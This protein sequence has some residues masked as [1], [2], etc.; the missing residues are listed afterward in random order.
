MN[1][2]DIYN[3]EKDKDLTRCWGRYSAKPITGTHTE[4]STEAVTISQTNR[5]LLSRFDNLMTELNGAEW[6]ELAESISVD[7][8]TAEMVMSDTADPRPV[9]Q[10]QTLYQT[11][12][13]LFGSW[14]YTW[15][16]G[17]AVYEVVTDKTITEYGLQKKTPFL[18][19]EKR[20]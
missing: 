2:K 19:S 8:I 10:I 15:P 4:A 13:Q 16:F 5:V 18:K 6:K 14:A 1:I 9:L 20:T 17:L 11:L 3:A 7:S 12:S